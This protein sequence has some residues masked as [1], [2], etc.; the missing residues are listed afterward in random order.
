LYADWDFLLRM[1]QAPGVP[2]NWL[3]PVEFKNGLMQI[4]LEIIEMTGT[5]EPVKLGLGWVNLPGALDTSIQHRVGWP[6]DFSGKGIYVGTMP[7]Q[8]MWYGPGYGEQT[9]PWDWTRSIDD[10]SIFTIIQPH[11]QNPFP[12]KI[13]VVATIIEN[14]IE[15]Q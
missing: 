1:N 14:K 3:N 7:V 10:K 11:G 9:L 8:S 13:H 12:V 5:P 2:S 15:Q 4:E 6:V